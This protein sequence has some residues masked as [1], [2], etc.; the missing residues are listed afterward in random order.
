[1]WPPQAGTMVVRGA[2]WSDVAEGE[3]AS[4]GRSGM[5]CL[6]GIRGGEELSSV[7]FLERLCG[8]AV[9][10]GACLGAGGA[11]RNGDPYRG[12]F[13]PIFAAEDEGHA[14]AKSEGSGRKTEGRLI[15]LAQQIFHARINGHE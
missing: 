3:R 4:D 1:L 12:L 15:V 9:G 14:S 7:P 13:A 11:A 10:L 5:I 8:S 2:A 6:I